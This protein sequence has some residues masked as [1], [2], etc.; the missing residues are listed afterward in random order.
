[1]K[2]TV[3]IQPSGH[4]IEVS[5][6][7]SILEA[8][9]RQKIIFPYGCQ[10]GVCGTCYGKVLE[11]EVS[12]PDKFPIGLSES[13]HQEGNALFC[14]AVAESDL[15]IEVAEVKQ[16]VALEVKT[17]PCKI[18]SLRQL[19]HDV[20]EVM[21]KLP[22]TQ[23]LPFLAGQYINFLLDDGK[24]RAFSLAGSS[25]DEGYLELHI[26]HI[27]GGVFSDQVFNQ[28]KEKAILRIKGPLGTFFLRDITRPI[29]LMGGGTG[30]APLKGMMEQ[31]IAE[32]ATEDIYLY[33]G[34]RAKEDLYHAELAKKW[35]FQHSN[36]HF[37]PVLSD[38][39]EGDQWQGR[40]G[41]VH[42]AVVEDFAD[43]SNVDVYMSGPPIMV[44]SGVEAFKKQ[45]LPKEQMYSDAFEYSDDALQSM[46]G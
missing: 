8:A 29:I 33:W 18:I 22:E 3:S 23:G 44:E 41:F 10:S 2:Y 24:E 20:M 35:A 11:G 16:K 6:G 26:R 14:K 30:F 12:Y 36:I 40:T 7:E 32:S 17:L 45:G 1:M 38:T 13:D 42:D 5:Q 43:L 37:I 25:N 46:K 19:S 28:L 31:L 21:L 15:V 27:K 9:L 4:Q 39:K 34:V